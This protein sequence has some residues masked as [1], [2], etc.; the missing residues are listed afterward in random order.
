MI[1][2]LDDFVDF[3]IE[4]FDT[5]RQDLILIEEMNELT[6]ELLKRRRNKNNKTQIAEEMAHTYISLRTVQKLFNI[7][8]E[9][10]QQQINV[11]RS[12]Y[13]V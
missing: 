3:I 7:S 6:K 9:E 2:K 4:R 12:E 13:N 5:N 10:L 1:N 11:K 8:D